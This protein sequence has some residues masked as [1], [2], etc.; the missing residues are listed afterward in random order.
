M[1]HGLVYQANQKYSTRWIAKDQKIPVFTLD[2]NNTFGLETIT[3]VEFRDKLDVT[4]VNEVSTIDF[5]VYPNPANDIINLITSENIKRLSITDMSGKTLVDQQD[6]SNHHQIDCSNWPRGI[7]L[8]K[9]ETG[10]KIS[11]EKIVLH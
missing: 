7:Y 5:S 11:T 4:S 2:V 9:L 1:P 6:I 3:K 8:L 10:E